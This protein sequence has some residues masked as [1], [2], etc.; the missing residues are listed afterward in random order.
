MTDYLCDTL[1]LYVF[2]REMD[3]YA[4]RRFIATP[5][6]YTLMQPAMPTWTMKNINKEVYLIYVASLHPSKVQGFCVLPLI[7]WY[8]SRLTDL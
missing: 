6:G 4:G 2:I 8:K 3:N 5:D 7:V 1:P